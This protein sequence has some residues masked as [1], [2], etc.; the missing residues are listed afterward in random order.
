M[1]THVGIELS[2]LKYKKLSDPFELFTFNFNMAA[3]GLPAYLDQ[4]TNQSIVATD[5]GHVTAVVYWFDLYLT[6]EKKLVTLDSSLHWRQAAVMQRSHVTVSTGTAV[7]VS[8][9]CKNSCVDIKV[10]A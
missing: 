8:A 3:E 4:A 2:T 6:P 9:K 1:S 10:T 5:A 7:T